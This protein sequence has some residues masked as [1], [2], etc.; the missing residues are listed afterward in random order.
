[1]THFLNSCCHSV[2]LFTNSD[3]VIHF[4]LD[5]I[6]TGSA[7]K[8]L[9][10]DQR[11][12]S[13]TTRKDRESSCFF[14]LLK[15][16]DIIIISDPYF[17]MKSLWFILIHL[18]EVSRFIRSLY[19]LFQFIYMRWVDSFLNRW[20][21]NPFIMIHYQ[22]VTLINLDSFRNSGSTFWKL[23]DLWFFHKENVKLWNNSFKDLRVCNPS[24]FSFLNRVLHHYDSLPNGGFLIQHDSFL[25]GWLLVISFN[26]QTVIH[27]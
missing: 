7:L 6:V 3:S 19:N 8:K 18:Q 22:M 27:Y 9:I 25:N 21:F 26:F 11:T 24:C 12:D 14:L 4:G 23:G 1:M 2:C 17:Q 20:L 13:F 15:W 10:L 16:S 5:A